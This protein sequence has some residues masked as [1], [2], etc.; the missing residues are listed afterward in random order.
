MRYIISVLSDSQLIMKLSGIRLSRWEIRN[1]SRGRH[2]L[3]KVGDS[4]L[5]A[6]FRSQCFSLRDKN[7]RNN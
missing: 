2:C 5:Q 1:S 7:A 4:N 6:R 3:N